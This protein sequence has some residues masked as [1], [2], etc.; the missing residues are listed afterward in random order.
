MSN[1]ALQI[2]RSVLP[3]GK[4]MAITDLNAIAIRGVARS[5]LGDDENT[6]TA[7]ITGA[8]NG[9]ACRSGIAG[10][11]QSAGQNNA[12]NNGAEHLMPQLLTRMP[13]IGWIDDWHE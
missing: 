12:P 3:V 5:A 1:P 9:C 7:V 6:S 11:R 2:H 10:R 4:D 13:S 8:R